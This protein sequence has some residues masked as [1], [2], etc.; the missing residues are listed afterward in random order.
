M[1]ILR[2][3]SSARN[4]MAADVGHSLRLDPALEPLREPFD[5]VGGAHAT[6]FAA[7]Q[8]RKGEEPVAGRG[9]R[10]PSKD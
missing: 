5:G 7:R 8:M 10:L 6:P 2:D 4:N 9:P 1:L 3:A